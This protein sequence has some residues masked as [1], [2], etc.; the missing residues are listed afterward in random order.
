MDP[1]L[2]LFYSWIIRTREELFAYTA[3]LPSEIYTR[4]HPDFAYGSV[5]NIQAHVANCY[6]VWVGQR[7]L[8]MERD[9]IAFEAASVPD[10]EAM[11]IKFAQ[12]DRIVEKACRVFEQPDVSFELVRPGRDR[13]QKR[14]WAESPRIYPWA[15]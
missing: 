11:R 3:S 10:A 15:G 7:G 4:E 6:L 5:R 14:V 12:V 13:L 1:S 2:A 9:Q 8:G